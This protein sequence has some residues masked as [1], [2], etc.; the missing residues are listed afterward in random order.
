M[1]WELLDLLH[2]C[3]VDKQNIPFPIHKMV[4]CVCICVCIINHNS[5]L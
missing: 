3:F 2:T 1:V 5:G 4:R